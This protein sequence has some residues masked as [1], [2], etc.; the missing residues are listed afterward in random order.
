MIAR[1]GILYKIT[2]TYSTP[3]YSKE[4]SM[5]RAKYPSFLDLK[6]SLLFFIAQMQDSKKKIGDL[7]TEAQV[8]I[9]TMINES[10]G[11][12]NHIICTGE[13]RKLYEYNNSKLSFRSEI[14]FG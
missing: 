3:L 14:L 12:L 7:P 10:F 6:E 13:K 5:L 4:Y 11:L 2:Y 9:Q 1:Q 8:C